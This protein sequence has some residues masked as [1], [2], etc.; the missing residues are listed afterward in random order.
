LSK[1]Y[2]AGDTLTVKIE[3][4]VPRGRGIGFADG[5]TVF[6]ALAA[7]GDTCKFA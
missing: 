1:E 6:V 3:R 5:L 4:I 7:P 2:K